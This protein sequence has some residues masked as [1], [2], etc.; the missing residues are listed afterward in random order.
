M[1]ND[2]MRTR[3]TRHRRRGL[4][5]RVTSAL[6]QLTAAMGAVQGH[7]DTLTGQSPRS[8]NSETDDA[9]T[10][11]DPFARQL[12]ASLLLELPQHRQ[13]FTAAW[14]ARDWQALADC[15]HRLAGAVAYCD[16]PELGAALDDLGNAVRN[17]DEQALLQA[18]NR[19]S[20][21]IDN[22]LAMSGLR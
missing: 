12:Y 1:N 14:L 8:G 21:E 15:S 10:M 2:S 5:T 19:A 9:S 17:S 20:R 6:A 18:Y 16:L 11:S 13:A 4:W 22:L 3:K 7:T